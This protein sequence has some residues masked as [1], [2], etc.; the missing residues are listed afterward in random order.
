MTISAPQ[1]SR[2][3]GTD[4]A[5]FTYQA[6]RVAHWN[7]QA[8]TSA[9][10]RTGKGYHQRLADVY[11]LLI[12]PG[13]RVL[14]LGCGRGD[15]LATVR[16]AVGM[17]VD[18]CSSRIAQAK[19]RHPTLQF[20]EADAHTYASSDK[21]DVV[22]LSDLINDLF[23]IQQTLQRVQAF[24]HSRS[25]VILNFYS[26]LWSLPLGLA[27]RLRLATPTL[28]Q[29]WLTV[30]DLANLLKLADFETLRSWNEV[31]WPF[32]TPLVGG[33]CNKFL[34][35]LPGIRHIGWTNFLIARPSPQASQQ[36]ILNR[37][38]KVSV[39][40]PI[41]NESGNIEPL[42]RRLPPLGEATELIFVEGH[43]RDDTLA[44]AERAIA[45]R[46][47]SDI[48]LLQQSGKG[49][50]D[51]VRLGFDTAVGDI[52]VILDADMTVAPEDL[53]RSINALRTGK[54]DFINCV[55][56]VYPMQSQA[57]RPLNFV[58][59]KFFGWAFSW[60]LAQPIKDTLCGTKVM[61]RE[62]YLR[63]AA[64]RSYFGEFDP[65]GDFDLLFGAAKLNLKI[66]D[67]PIRYRDRTYGETN[68][69]RWKHGWLLLKMTGVAALR[70]KFV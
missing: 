60:L 59:N 56:L 47:G 19:A 23:D 17:G 13:Q 24:C 67:L 40:V 39:V 2:R 1:I 29:N 26:R 64:N 45:D 36:E 53:P 48:R 46:P 50:A 41:R 30:Q 9:E 10:A 16:P 20:V 14:E 5:F 34:V 22:I 6:E 38:A 61:W 68:I 27:A 12:M 21:Y 3:T 66:I 70:L 51:A 43:S 55:R 31:L 7:R 25:R 33:F 54:G 32:R 42:I 57:M 69:S 28:A 4:D 44:V 37:P 15:L 8:N 35:K 52:L 18:F 49:K 11:R 62:D 65:F 63:L 58:G